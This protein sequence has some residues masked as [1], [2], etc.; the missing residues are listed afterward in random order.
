[1]RT[2]LRAVEARPALAAVAVELPDL[3]PDERAVLAEA[4]TAGRRFEATAPGLAR[5]CAAFAEAL[6]EGRV[7]AGAKAP[8]RRGKQS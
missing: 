7:P 1:M 6:A 4:V 5:F 8:G 3:T 2:A